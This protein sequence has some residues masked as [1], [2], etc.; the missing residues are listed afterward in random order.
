MQLLAI[1][2][3]KVAKLIKNNH[4]NSIHPKSV[5]D[6]CLRERTC[7]QFSPDSQKL[8]S[9]CHEPFGDAASRRSLTLVVYKFLLG[10]F[11]FIARIAS[12]ILYVFQCLYIFSG[13]VP[14]IVDCMYIE[15]KVLLPKTQCSIRLSQYGRYLRYFII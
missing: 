14:Y 3:N 11:H 1:G 7:I 12:E 8:A 5:Y 6:D 15:L 13:I 9:Y 2:Q 4:R 10:S